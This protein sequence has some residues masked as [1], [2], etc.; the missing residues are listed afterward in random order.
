MNRRDWANAGRC[1]GKGL[2]A[3]CGVG[4]LMGFSGCAFL[5]SLRENPYE[6]HYFGESEEVLSEAH[7]PAERRTVLMENHAAMVDDFKQHGYEVLGAA[8]FQTS[9]AP[10]GTHLPKQARKVGANL[11]VWSRRFDRNEQRL[12]NSREY[13]PGERI[14]VNGTTVETRGRWV[15]SIE[16]RNWDYYDYK[17][18]FL[19]WR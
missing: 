13:L 18:T 16:V 19:R 15:N 10:G 11:V 8:E 12:V 3:L 5:D 4:L 9:N 17:A 14:T 7:G 2:V 1:L 6:S